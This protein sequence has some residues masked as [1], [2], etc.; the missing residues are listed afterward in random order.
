V[1]GLA[2]AVLLLLALPVLAAAAWLALLAVLAR[3][4]PPPPEVA[5]RTRFAVVVPAHDEEAGIGR[6]VENLRAAAWPAE[7]RRV[8]VVADNCSD[9]T[10][11][12]AR[13]AGA[14]VLVRTDAAR[15]G[16]GYALALAFETVLREGWADAV[17]VVDADTLVS[18]NLL[19]AFAARLE[20]GARA[21]QAHYAVRD[22]DRSWRT[23]LMALAFSIFHGAR[24]LGRERLGVSSGLRG[25]GMCFTP[26]VL[27]AVPHDAF[28]VVEDLEYGVRLGEAGIRVEYV[29]EAEVKGDMPAT[30]EASRPQRRRWEG[31]RS[32]L[33]RTHAGRLLRRALAERDLVLFDLFMDLAVPP[34]TRL[35]ALTSGGVVASA[36][37]SAWAGRPLVALW[38]WLAAALCLTLYVLRG[39]RLAGPGGLRD[40]LF[41][42]AYVAWKIGLLLR[43]PA[44]PK[45]AWVRTP[46][47][48]AP[49]R[50]P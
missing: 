38:P 35:V 21:L 47:E 11:E 32:T 12:R 44:A 50:T 37:A 4:R 9:R 14:E 43:R 20:R 39:A 42:P 1:T 24:S 29:P 49:P 33:F 46:R 40:L 7:R 25:N 19:S 5:P 13:E 34:L 8:L 26:G 6:T 16:K 28:S 36:L 45:T 10:A 2:D 41:A 30:E 23:R 22:P 17:V 31:G 15:R 27:A 18:P 48:G 3:P